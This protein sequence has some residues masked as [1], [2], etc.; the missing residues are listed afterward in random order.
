[1]L[2]ENNVEIFPASW[3]QSAAAI[4]SYDLSRYDDEGVVKDVVEQEGEAVIW[5]GK[6]L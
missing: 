2:S 4:Y 5:P 1:M 6:H 3:V